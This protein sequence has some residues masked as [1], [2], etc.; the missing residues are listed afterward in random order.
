MTAKTFA[1][2]VEP[3]AAELAG[4]RAAIVETARSL[5]AEAWQRPSPLDGWAYRDLLTHLATGDWV[6]QHI[7]RSVLANET[8]N[9]GQIIDMNWVDQGNAKLLQERRGRSVQ[10]LIAEV[11]AEGE[12]TQELLTKL[13]D[14]H[15]GQTQEGAPM[16]LAAYLGAVFPGHDRDHLAQLRTALE[17]VS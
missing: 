8:L 10:E 7:L 3:I 5:G 11:E 13:T 17:H 16:T 14:E 6:C 12:E 2:W 15:E 4:N 1:P 9:V